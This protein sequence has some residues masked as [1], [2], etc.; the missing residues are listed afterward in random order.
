MPCPSRA[1]W[2]HWV[3]TQSGCCGLLGH[4]GLAPHSLAPGCRA[5]KIPLAFF[6]SLCSP[7]PQLF[8]CSHEVGSNFLLLPVHL[9]LFLCRSLWLSRLGNLFTWSVLTLCKLQVSILSVSWDDCLW[10]ETRSFIIGLYKI[11]FTTRLCVYI[12]L[13]KIYFATRMCVLVGEI[14]CCVCVFVMC[15]LGRYFLVGKIP[16]WLN[17][18]AAECLAFL[19]LPLSLPPISTVHYYKFVYNPDRNPLFRFSYRDERYQNNTF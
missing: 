8:P 2:S 12:G 15:W 6:L 19:P 11:Y 17:F 4:G 14:F 10:Y 3:G 7:P 13:C 18:L 16:S 1:H 9:F 5:F